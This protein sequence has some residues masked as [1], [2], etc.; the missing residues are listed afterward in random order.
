MKKTNVL[1]FVM[2][3]CIVFFLA[4]GVTI[5]SSVPDKI[6]LFKGDKLNIGKF[7]TADIETD[8]SG[9]LRNGE[10][11]DADR[12]YFAK[13]KFFGLVPVKTVQV[14]VIETPRLIPGGNC[15]GVKL[16]TDGLV[17]VGTSSFKSSDGKMVFPAKYAGVNEGDVIKE[18]NG[19]AIGD[20]KKFSEIVTANNGDDVL[21]T[22]DRNGMILKCSVKPALDKDGKFKLGIW[23]RSSLAGIGTMTYYDP[24]NNTYGALGHGISDS[25]TG[26]VV[27]IS[28]GEVLKA[29]VVSVIKGEKGSPGELRGSFV[30]DGKIADVERN[31]DCGI[32]G[33]ITD[34]EVLSKKPMEVASHNEI[35]EGKAQ[36]LSCIDG[37][38]IGAY[39]IE[40]QKV[41]HRK[42]NDSKSMVIKITDKELLNETGGILQGMSGS[43][44]LQNGKLIGAV[45][46]VFVNDPTRGYGIFIEN[47]LSE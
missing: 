19:E 18:I 35:K 32:Y 45:T 42:T 47:M 8:F 20:S 11:E 26:R 29:E 46:H 27:P 7:Y 37:D 36:I 28:K 22:I 14:S 40:I 1:K 43:P 9:V 23:V 38:D 4:L 10:I 6:I 13:V 24:H 17:V 41:N 33:S 2:S 39:D 12:G 34:A 44:I 21:L 30:M 25:D 31:T 3:F 5:V 16:Y 15:I